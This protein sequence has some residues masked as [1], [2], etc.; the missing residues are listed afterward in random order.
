M[1]LTNQPQGNLMKTIKRLLSSTAY[2]NTPGWKI[3][4]N[5]SVALK[6]GNPVYIDS[7]GNEKY[8]ALDT[9]SR[10]NGEAKQHREAKE[11]LEAKIKDFEGIDAKKAREALETVSKLE[12]KQLID[13]GK[14]DEV[15]NQITQQ[16]NTQMADKDKAYA[17]LSAKYDNMVIN[18]VFANSEFI[19]NNIAV[20]RDMF[21]A[22]FRNNFKVE[23][24]EVVV[25]GKDG[26]RLYS[27][28]RAGEYATPEEALKL[29]TESHPQKDVI[30][31]ADVGTGTGNSGG[32]GGH[33]SGRT[34]KRSE[35]EKLSPQKQAEFASKMRSG[36]MKI[37]D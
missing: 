25:Y 37:V 30:L 12:A 11:A 36:E 35:F 28:E 13:A 20:P 6:D 33:G 2:N 17:D 16:F 3:D 26:N 15:K 5:G 4:E 24:G 29:L 31:K 18:N 23:N 10:L 9:I 8:V 22:T 34:M 32:G 27:K 19:R 7:S 21:E 1:T 14:V